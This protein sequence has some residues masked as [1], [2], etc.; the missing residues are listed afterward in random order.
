MDLKAFRKIYLLIE[1]YAS[2][3][4]KHMTMTWTNENI[5]NAVMDIVNTRGLDHMPSV[6]EIKE[7]YG[8]NK[9]TN[10]IT[11]HGGQGE[12]A[13]ILGLDIK[14]SE[15]QFGGKYEKYVHD[16]LTEIGFDCELTGT[17]CPYDLLVNGCVKIDVKASR[18]TRINGYDAYS[19]RLA[20]AMQTCDVYIL[21]GIDR[22]EYK[23]MYVIPA[24]E[25][26]GQVQICISTTCSKYDIYIDRFDIIAK[27]SEAFRQV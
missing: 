27:L 18:I 7:Y 14:Q 8:N 5:A 11:K 13:N 26:N 10:A 20:K 15:T 19:F 12:W 24:H 25:V 2:R 1:G 6:S 17:R 22:L 23:K 3:D 9:L 21:V 4:K 16:F